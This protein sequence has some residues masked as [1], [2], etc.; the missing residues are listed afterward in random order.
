MI[1]D[2]IYKKRSY[3][4]LNKHD[5]ERNGAIFSQ[6]K[7]RLKGMKWSEQRKIKQEF[8]TNL[9]FQFDKEYVSYCRSDNNKVVVKGS[10][11]PSE[12]YGPIHNAKYN[13]LKSG[14]LR[15]HDV[16]P[17]GELHISNNKNISTLFEN[18]F[19]FLFVDE[20]QDSVVHL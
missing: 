19:L 8:F 14:Y 1:D 18:R 6:L 17:L 2:D 10:K 20:M 7:D 3:I 15:Y 12:S 13:L 11:N 9:K 5:L 4:E 16:F